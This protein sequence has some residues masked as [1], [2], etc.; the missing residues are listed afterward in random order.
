MMKK[1]IFILLSLCF[2]ISCKESSSSLFDEDYKQL[3]EN[4]INN[5]FNTITLNA[6]NEE[7][8]LFRIEELDLS[9]HSYYQELKEKFS[10]VYVL[11]LDGNNKTIKNIRSFVAI[12]NEDEHLSI[13]QVGFDGNKKTIEKNRNEESSYKGLQFFVTPF[14]PSLSKVHFYFESDGFDGKYYQFNVKKEL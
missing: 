13:A 6:I 8:N 7:E 3:T 1:K 11:T 4:V 2:L 14:Y 5:E 12:E 9:L 10:Y